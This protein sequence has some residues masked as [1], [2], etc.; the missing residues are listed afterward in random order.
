[1]RLLKTIYEKTHNRPAP[2]YYNYS[3]KTVLFKPIRKWLT[4]TVAANCPFNCIRI[5]IYRMCG[6]KIGKGTFIGMRCY[7]DDMC[8][9][10]LRIGDNVIISYGVYFACHGKGQEHLPITVDDGAYIGMRASIISKNVKNLR[11]GGTYLLPCNSWSVHTGQPG[12]SRKY[13]GCWNTM[14]NHL[15]CRQFKCEVS[16]G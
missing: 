1:M 9:D 10:L 5:A 14:Q 2:Y 15:S 4:N 8:Y 3:L 11:G 7:L 12:R 16:A 6:F 13:N